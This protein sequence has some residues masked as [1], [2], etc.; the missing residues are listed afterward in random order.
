MKRIIFKIILLILLV[1][2]SFTSA[3]SSKF[4]MDADYSIFR[5]SDTKSVLE[6]YFDFYQG[7]FRY[8]YE[9]NYFVAHAVIGFK[10][11]DD[12]T[13]TDVVNKDFL[14]DIPT[15]DTS[16]SKLKS[17]EISQ[18]TLF[19]DAGKNY[20]LMLLGSDNKSPER[21]DSAT[22]SF[23]VPAYTLS[24]VKMSH[25]QLSTSVEK[26]TNKGSSF[27]KFGY[28]VVPNPNGL[29]GNSL[30]SLYYYYELYGLKSQIGGEKDAELRTYVISTHGD[31][32][33]SKTEN[34]KCSND[35]MTL[36][37]SFNVDTLKRD[38]YVLKLALY[39]EGSSLAESERK[40][41]VYNAD[42]VNYTIT[43]DEGF[44]KSEFITFTEKMIDEEFDK[45]LYVRTSADKNEY[46]RMKT[47]DEKRK[48]LYR[49]WKKRDQ[50]PET[51]RIEIRDE[52]FKRMKEAN[53]KFK[54][55]FTDGWKSDR[56]RIFILYG[57][58]NEIE[59]HYMEANTKNYEIWTYDN[60]QGGTMCVFGE[61]VSTEEGSYYLMHSTIKNE[62]TDNDWKEKLRKM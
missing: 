25:I 60:L 45:C 18:I 9:N 3:Q 47:L 29:Y 1:S 48:F 35:I 27:Y 23:Y 6:V 43:D 46:E 38:S 16:S 17:K 61:T 57:P 13:K 2:P 28:E 24:P 5:Y 31:T 56:G 32:V 51:P 36:Y 59:R 49:F 8:V 30:K 15:T 21:R 53:A 34:I 12:E 62:L 42:K 33:I 4:L 22:F 20:T 54:Q 37:G 52:Y 40:F 26:S 50:S 55:S 11:T 58:P 19:V 14:L 44:L 41:V 10:L 7:S 39:S